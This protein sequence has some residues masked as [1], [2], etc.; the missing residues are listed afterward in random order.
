MN[1]VGIIGGGYL[2]VILSFVGFFVGFFILVY[3]VVKI[4]DMVESIKTQL[5]LDSEFNRKQI[6]KYRDDN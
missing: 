6:K 5:M 4:K 1:I 2:I 3:K